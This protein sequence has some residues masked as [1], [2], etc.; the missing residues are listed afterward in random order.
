M[1][2]K[3][4]DFAILLNEPDF[5]GSEGWVVGFKKRHK[6]ECYLKYGE[7]ASASIEALDDMHKNLQNIFADYSPNDIFNADEIGLYWKMEPNCTLSTRPGK[8]I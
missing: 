4:N 1:A 2:Q 7:S 3:A 8:Y 5:K 6:L